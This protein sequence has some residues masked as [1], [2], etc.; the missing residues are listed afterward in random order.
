MQL[1]QTACGA[2]FVTNAATSSKLVIFASLRPAGF[3]NAGHRDGVNLNDRE[4][5]RPYLSVDLVGTGGIIHECYA[6][7]PLPARWAA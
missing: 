3:Q 6:M 4:P 7:G 2:C 5:P 1:S